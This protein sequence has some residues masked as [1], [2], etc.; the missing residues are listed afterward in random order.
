MIGLA[1]A[2]AAEERET[3]H[4]HFRHFYDFSYIC[5]LPVLVLQS[6]MLFI[7]RALRDPDSAGFTN[8]ESRP[9]LGI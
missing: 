9:N 2:A 3:S 6:T 5:L 4:S 1:A 8:P 7:I